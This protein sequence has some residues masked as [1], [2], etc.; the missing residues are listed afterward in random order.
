MAALKVI[1]D[2]GL[3]TVCCLR[4]VGTLN[5]ILK[6]YMQVL[7]RQLRLESIKEWKIGSHVL[8]AE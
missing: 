4:N 8:S 5:L 6:C 7:Q 3:V 2:R 1:G